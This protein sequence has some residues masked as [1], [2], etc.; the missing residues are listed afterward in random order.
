MNVLQKLQLTAGQ[1][2]HERYFGATLRIFDTDIPCTHT[3]IE[4]DFELVPGGQSST[5]L[6][7]AITFRRAALPANKVPRKGVLCSL[8]PTSDASPI[9][10]KLWSGG[11]LPGNEV[12]QFMAVDANYRA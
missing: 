2:I 4:R 10:L 9:A 1:K 12:Y 3:K 8:K 7:K 11:E 5:T 6:V